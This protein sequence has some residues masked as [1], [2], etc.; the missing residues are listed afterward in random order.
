MGTLMNI[1]YVSYQTALKWEMDTTTADFTAHNA[2]DFPFP[3][4]Q[5]PH[6]QP[7]R[8]NLSVADN[9]LLQPKNPFDDKEPLLQLLDEAKMTPIDKDTAAQLPTWTQISQLYGNQPIYHG[10]DTCTRFQGAG[11]PAQHF[12]G[13]A[14]TFNSGTNLLAELLIANCHMPARMAAFGPRQR[15]IRWQVVWGKHTP[16][17]NETFRQLHRTYT[18]MPELTA[19]DVFAAVIIRDPYR[20]MQSMCKHPYA[21]TWGHADSHCPSLVPNQADVLAQ[22]HLADRDHIPVTVEYSNFTRHYQ[23]L[24]HFWNEWYQGESKQRLTRQLSGKM[25]AQIGGGAKI[26]SPHSCCVSCFPPPW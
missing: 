19:D 17:G 11:S 2:P 26:T 16:V 24:V 23:S 18:D 12:L 3:L 6:F 8:N 22:P 7:P 9:N 21:A 13:I 1:G 5:I 15:G 10:L 14:G 20:W 25:C 4:E